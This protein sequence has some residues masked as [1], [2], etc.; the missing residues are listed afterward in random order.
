MCQ[1]ALAFV[2]RSLVVGDAPASTSIIHK[3]PSILVKCGC[4]V[5]LWPF[6][7]LDFGFFLGSMSFLH[8]SN[9]SMHLFYSSIF[10]HTSC[11]SSS[12]LIH[13]KFVDT[14]SLASVIVVVP[15]CVGGD[16]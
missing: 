3:H 10:L 6:I 11:L 16:I 9:I 15:C 4:R 14:H 13:S 2:P 7:N 1:N 8:Y 5:Q 12:L